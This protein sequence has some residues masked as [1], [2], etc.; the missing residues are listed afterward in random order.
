M[1]P[2]GSTTVKHFDRNYKLKWQGEPH[3]RYLNSVLWWR[4]CLASP[5]GSWRRHCAC[6]WLRRRTNTKDG[7]ARSKFH[8]ISLASL[9]GRESIKSLEIIVTLLP[10]QMWCGDTPTRPRFH[11]KLDYA[12]HLTSAAAALTLGRCRTEKCKQ[13]KWP[14]KIDKNDNNSIWCLPERHI[15][16]SLGS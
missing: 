4:R 5:T 15:L 7:P 12:L 11:F 16:S 3:G 14:F 13:L 1:L 10:S 6:P 2:S 8:K 9:C